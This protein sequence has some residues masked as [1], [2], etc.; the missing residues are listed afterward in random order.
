MRDQYKPA[1]GQ[2]SKYTVGPG[3][4]AHM[5]LPLMRWSKKNAERLAIVRLL[6][7]NDGLDPN[8]C[9]WYSDVESLP[10]GREVQHL[11]ALHIAA[12]RGDEEMV[13]LLLEFGAVREMR[14][15]K[16]FLPKERAAAKGHRRVVV[17]L[18]EGSL[19]E[20]EPEGKK[21]VEP[22]MKSGSKSK[23][24]KKM[25]KAAV[26]KPALK[27][28]SAAGVKKPT[29]SDVSKPPLPKGKT[30]SAVGTTRSSKSRRP[31]GRTREEIIAETWRTGI[32][33][34]W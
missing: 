13:E 16:G 1:I 4:S 20:K 25:A 15:G 10:D 32:G 30:K 17:L 8:G 23:G 6:L 19:S 31:Y 11:T 27:G 24:V 9:L 33:D 29:K 7:E 21:V 2:H 12:D 34:I 18:E 3:P 26:K 14:D 5:L 22:K 28:K